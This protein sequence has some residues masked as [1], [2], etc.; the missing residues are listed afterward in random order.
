MGVINYPTS[1]DSWVTKVD[2]VDDIMSQHINYAQ[3]IVVALENK[4]GVDTSAVSTSLDYKVNNFFVEDVRKMWFYENAAPTGWEIVTA[5][6]DALVVVKGG[7]S[8]YN[9]TG[10]NIAGTWLATL[11]ILTEAEMGMHDH[12]YRGV[13]GRQSVPTGYGDQPAARYA[14]TAGTSTAA[15][16]GG[17]HRHGSNTYRPYAAV[18]II[19]KFTGA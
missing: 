11:H 3:D 13:A 18:G 6:S 10:S 5:A 9:V 15:G 17:G 4:V 2:S 14:Y 8:D 16:G 7:S 1:L 12:R 19:A